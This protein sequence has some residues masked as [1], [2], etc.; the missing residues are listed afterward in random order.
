MSGAAIACLVA[1]LLLAA[2]TAVFFRRD[3]ERARAAG[4]PASPLPPEVVPPRV[5]DTP[6]QKSLTRGVQAP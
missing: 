3:Y 4:E 5:G 1:A 2:A 6:V